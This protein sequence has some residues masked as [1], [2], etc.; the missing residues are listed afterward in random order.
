MNIFLK[1]QTRHLFMIACSNKIISIIVPVYNASNYITRC[2]ESVKTQSYSNWELILVNDGSTDS[3]GK[4]LDVY[5][6]DDKRIKVFHQTNCGASAARNLGIRNATGA[7]LTFLDADDYLYSD[8][9]ENLIFT[10]AHNDC[11]IVI[12]DF[13]YK[14]NGEIFRYHHTRSLNTNQFIHDFLA[15][16]WVI[17][18]GSLIKSSLFKSNGIQFPEGVIYSEDFSAILRVL[19]AAS[20]ISNCHKICYHY[21]RDNEASLTHQ[22][23]MIK[24]LNERDIYLQCLSYIKERNLLGLYEEPLVWRLLKIEQALI[25]DYNYFNKF[26]ENYPCKIQY[27]FSCNFISKKM[28]VLMWL[29]IRNHTFLARVILRFRKTK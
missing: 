24:I 2:I 19:L 18:W 22:N 12:G 29:V 14:I 28:K 10:Q 4:I 6:L 3:S 8:A 20:S 16:S 25:Y 27:L 1:A 13:E 7:F 5:G 21:N 23:D 26:R 15:S 11:D 17:I 9:L